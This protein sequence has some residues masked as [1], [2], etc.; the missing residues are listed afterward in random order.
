MRG[1]QPCPR[2]LSLPASPCGRSL[3]ARSGRFGAPWQRWHFGR[4]LREHRSSDKVRSAVIRL[5][6]ALIWMLCFLSPPSPAL[7]KG[8]LFRLARWRFGSSCLCSAVHPAR[9]AD[10]RGAR[11]A[12]SPALSSQPRTLRGTPGQDGG[13]VCLSRVKSQWGSLLQISSKCS[14]YLLKSLPWASCPGG[15]Y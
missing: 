13:L 6:R 1:W 14:S 7:W 12:A 15:F 8:V 10:P 2:P 4:A 9:P 11:G 3:A 5:G